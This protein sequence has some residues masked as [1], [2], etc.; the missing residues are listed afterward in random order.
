MMRASNAHIACIGGAALD[1]TYQ[2]VSAVVAETSNP[3]VS[4]RGFG[5]VARNVAENLARLETAASLATMVGEDDGGRAMLRDLVALGVDVDDVTMTRSRP[6][7]EYVAIVQPGGD[8]FVGAADM[9]IFDLIDADFLDRIWPKLSRADWIFA[10]CNLPAATLGDLIGRCASSRSK[11]AVDAVSTAKV[12][13]LP[14]R[15]N[16]VDLLFLNRDEA[17]ALTYGGA[18][19]R[20]DPASLAKQLQS[21]GARECVI[22]L[23]AEGLAIASI[24]GTASIPAAPCAQIDV[25]GAGDALIAGTLHFI[26]SGAPLADAARAGAVLA[27]LT[28]EREGSVRADLTPDLFAAALRRNRPSH[29]GQ[30]P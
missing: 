12:E 20:N 8:L 4:R 2:A 3:V 25:T 21:Q 26:A 18:P 14:R 16:G 27:A 23:S 22:T 11:L 30:D 29:A 9:A 5:G 10:D 6:T 28:T 1:R 24:E 15:L 7:A 17:R 13:R 19:A